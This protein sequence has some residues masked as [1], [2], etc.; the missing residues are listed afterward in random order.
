MAVAILCRRLATPL[1]E[2]MELDLDLFE[3]MFAAAT[4]ALK[5]ET[6]YGD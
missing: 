4:E 3:H 6:P 1:G 2:V 5:L